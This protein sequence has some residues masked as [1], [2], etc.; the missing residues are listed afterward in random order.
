MSLLD[1]GCG[2]LLIEGLKQRKNTKFMEQELH[3]V[4][5]SIVNFREESGK[6]I[7]KI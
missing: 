4:K 2:F 3:Y 1:I 7:W 5:S 6:N